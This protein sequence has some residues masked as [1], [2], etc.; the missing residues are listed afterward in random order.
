MKP[1]G[2]KFDATF[3]GISVVSDGWVISFKV[4]KIES[5]KMMKLYGGSESLQVSVLTAKDIA[6]IYGDEDE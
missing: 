2:I 6:N 4:P 5:E 1:K 3:Y